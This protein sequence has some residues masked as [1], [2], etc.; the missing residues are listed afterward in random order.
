LLANE[1]DRALAL[2]EHVPRRGLGSLPLDP[3][4]ECP[5]SRDLVE[6]DLAVSHHQVPNLG[7]YVLPAAVCICARCRAGDLEHEDCTRGCG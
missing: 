5:L 7:Y 6:D 4:E 3:I 2:I 1:V